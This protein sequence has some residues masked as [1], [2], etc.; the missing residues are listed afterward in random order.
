MASYPGASRSVI[1]RLGA[2]ESWARTAD[3]SARTARARAQFDARFEREARKRLGLDAT[4]RQIAE[5][6][7]SARKAYFARLALA[8]IAARKQEIIR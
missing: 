6:A 1:A 5:A 7:A 3:R 2:H 8:S 4:P